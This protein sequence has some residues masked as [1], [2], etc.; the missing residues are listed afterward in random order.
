MAVAEHQE[1]KKLFNTQNWLKNQDSRLKVQ[2]A[3][4]MFMGMVKNMQGGPEL[5]KSLTLPAD[6]FGLRWVAE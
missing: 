6:K 4:A 5:K 3:V 1:K 2:A